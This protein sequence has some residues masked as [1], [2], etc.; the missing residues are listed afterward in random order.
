M[1]RPTRENFSVIIKYFQIFLL[2]TTKFLNF[3]LWCKVIDIIT[4]NQHN[5]PLG[6]KRIRKLRTEM[7]KYIIQN[8]PKGSSK[9]S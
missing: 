4:I 1:N 9:Y 7:N 5:T 3:E 6:L 8:N 2:K